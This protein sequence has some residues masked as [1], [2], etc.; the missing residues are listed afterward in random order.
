V[1]LSRRTPIDFSSELRRIE[2]PGFKAPGVQGVSTNVVTPDYFTTF[3]IGL[4]RGRGFTPQDQQNAPNVALV[5]EAM[6][7]FFYGETDPIGRSFRL[8]GGSQQATWTIVGIVQDVRQEHL[9]ADAPTRMVYT[10]LAQAARG[11]DARSDS[12]SRLTVE[13][14]SGDAAAALTALAASAREEARAVSKD[15][16]VSYVR[17][18]D[19]QLDASLIRERVLATL[20]TAF[21]ALALVLSAV[22]LYGVMAYTVARRS[23]E[24]GIKLALG[25]A[26]RSVLLHVLRDTLSVSAAGIA[27]G[28]IAAFVLA[29]GVSAFLFGLAPRDPLTLVGSAAVLLVTTLVAGYLPAR[30]AAAVDP[31]Q[32]LRT[33]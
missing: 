11:V 18:M 9:R 3:G 19:E 23:R 33:E 4:V 31:M 10:P 1:S 2:V 5:S 26:R 6:S 16:V 14:R 12:L 21:S 32:A 30:K 22:G 7:R 15:A 13:I 20:S 17:T 24:I 25:A 27:A 8:G 28:V 29:E